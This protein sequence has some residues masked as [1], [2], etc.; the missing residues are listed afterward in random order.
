MSRA[1]VGYQLWFLREAHGMFTA[2]PATEEGLHSVIRKLA[3]QMTERFACGHL[4]RLYPR[5]LL[6][7]RGGGCG[8]SRRRR[9]LL[10]EVS[11]MA[12][13]R[14]GHIRTGEDRREGGVNPPGAS[15]IGFIYAALQLS[16]WLGSSTFW[17]L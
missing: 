3:N 5:M 16:V 13:E 7:R 11:F 17:Q 9:I 12:S 8:G 10:K 14:I 4:G 2:S 1:D 6:T 15:G